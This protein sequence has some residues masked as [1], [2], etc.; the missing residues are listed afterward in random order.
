MARAKEPI[1]LRR[2][3]MASGR[4]SLFLDVYINGVRSYEF[5]KMY[6]IQEKTREDREKNRQTLALAE[7]VRSKRVVELQNNRFGF[8]KIYKEDTIFLD[9]F[10]YMCED[11]MVPRNWTGC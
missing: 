5:L 7:A 4:E 11:I 2:R 6:L 10:R 8:E 1:R 3:R 9:Y